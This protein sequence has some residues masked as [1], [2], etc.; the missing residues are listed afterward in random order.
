MEVFSLGDDQY[1]GMFITQ[2]PS[3][4]SDSEENSNKSEESSLFLGVE[5]TDFGSPSVLPTAAKEKYRPE[6]SD[7]SDDEFER[8]EK[9]TDEAAR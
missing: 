7:I 8:I 9:I 3:K 6:F 1:E 2:E 4:R 5:D